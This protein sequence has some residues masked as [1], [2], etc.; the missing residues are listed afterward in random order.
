[1][2]KTIA[3][4]IAG[5][6]LVGSQAL[7]QS[8]AA[9]RVSDR[10]GAASGEASEFSGGIPAGLIFVAVAAAGFWFVT[11]VNDEGESD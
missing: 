1:M 2:K 10:L 8:A 4:A 11:E 3:A 7:A 6:A 5:L 9:P